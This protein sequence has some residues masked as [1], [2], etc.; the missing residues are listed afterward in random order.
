[1]NRPLIS[2]ITVV[3]NSNSTLEFTLQSVLNQDK[4]LFEYW[5]IDG[6]STDGSAATI[7][8]YEDQL[9]GWISEPD[10]GIFDA[11]NKGIERAKGDWLFFL[12]ADD[13]LT[14]DIFSKV[15]PYLQPDLRVV[16]GDVLL[17]NG[18]IFHS[19]IGI[20]CLFE[21][22][23]HHQS[24]FYHR[25][26]FN[27][28]RYNQIFKNAA[29]Y[30]LTLRIYTQ[31]QPSLFIPHIISIFSTGGYSS[32]SGVGIKVGI[33]DANKIRKIYLQSSLLNYMLSFA[34]Q[35]YYPYMHKRGKVIAKIRKLLKLERNRPNLK[36]RHGRV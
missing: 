21:N 13:T 34:L 25:V 27:T 36:N 15:V 5:I 20:R 35:A 18:A 14:T 30:E 11:M 9:A 6:G 3:Y 28:F 8:K 23:L 31:K 17:D 29:D 10:K 19:H 26:L 1:M 22:R 4:N 2:V 32:E 7:K 33:D 16:Y 12:G 24:A